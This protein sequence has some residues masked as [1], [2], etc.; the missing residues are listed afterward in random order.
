VS[1]RPRL[2]WFPAP[3]SCACFHAPRMPDRTAVHQAVRVPVSSFLGVSP[4]QSSFTLTSVRDLSESD[5]L[6]GFRP[7]SRHDRNAS[8]HCPRG[9]QLPLGS[10]HRRSQPLDGF[11]RAP[12]PGLVS[13]PS[14]V[15]GPIPF[16]GFSLR[17]ALLPHREQVPP[18]R[19]AAAGSPNCGVRRPP[20]TA[21]TSGLRSARSSVHHAEVMSFGEGRSPL[22]V[23]VSTRSKTCR[24]EPRLPRAIRS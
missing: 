4:L 24:R 19:S 12:A 1:F 20:V 18:C 14:R 15:Q 6:P 3:A 17:A 2:I 11:L 9:F 23:L 13:S 7:S 8:T 10:V 22:R 21:P 16:R 5:S